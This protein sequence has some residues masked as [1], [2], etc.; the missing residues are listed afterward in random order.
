[1]AGTPDLYEVWGSGLSI[2]SVRVTVTG[3]VA[4]VAAQLV[5]A[6]ADDQDIGDLLMAAVAR[7]GDEGAGVVDFSSDSLLLRY[8]ARRA[9]FAGA[10]RVP[11]RAQIDTIG[12]PTADVAAVDDVGAAGRRERTAALVG[13]LGQ[14]GVT[15]TGAPP[16]RT[17][18]RMAR[19]LAGGVRDTLEVVVATAVDRSVTISV[20]D[21]YDLMAEP[22]ALTADTTVAVFHRFPAQAAA[23]GRIAFDQAVYGLKAGLYAGVAEGSVSE[24][25]LMVG[26]VTIEAFLRSL[27]DRDGR[28]ATSPT[29]RA[30]GPFTVVDGTVAHELWHRIEFM[31]EAQ[32]F[33]SSME[34]R[35]Q[36]G[37]HLGVETLE[38]AVKGDTDSAPAPWRAAHR[39]LAE[40]VS[41][42]ATTNPREATAEMFKL[43]WCRNGETS[44]LVTRFGQLLEQFF[45]P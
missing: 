41:P 16:A 38:Q 36:L 18:G 13:A 23:V 9:G 37:L 2:G 8:A 19:R 35:R 14:L 25:H 31:F 30:P 17:F 10:L 21:R 45:G 4:A 29:A 33:R 28:S 11:L 6:P 26:Y 43:W 44:D 7:A 32:D 22:V 24:V 39:R 42:Y 40:E 3:A 1:V 12:W 20:P 27:R 34:F 15:A 5:R